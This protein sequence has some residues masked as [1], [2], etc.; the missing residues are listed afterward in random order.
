MSAAYQSKRAAQT[1]C[2]LWINVSPLINDSEPTC[3]GTLK[4]GRWRV[5]TSARPL[6]AGVVIID[7]LGRG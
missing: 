5:D 7:D 2:A 1:P 4:L 6:S 3:A